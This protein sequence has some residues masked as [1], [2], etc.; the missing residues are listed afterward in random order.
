MDFNAEK[1]K[2]DIVKWIKDWFNEN[3]KGCKGVLGISGGKDRDS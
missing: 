2:N 1:V 3:G